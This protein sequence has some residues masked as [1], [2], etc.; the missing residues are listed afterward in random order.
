MEAG[1]VVP[2]CFRFSLLPALAVTVY[3]VNAVSSGLVGQEYGHCNDA[4]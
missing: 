2:A 3:V 4:G 1:G